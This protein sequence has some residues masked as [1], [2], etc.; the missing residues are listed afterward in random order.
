MRAS[1]GT[2]G[3]AALDQRNPR[4]TD[5]VAEQ[6]EATSATAE[7]AEEKETKARLVRA[8]LRGEVSR[9]GFLS[10]L[11]FAWALFTGATVGMLGAMGRFI[12]SSTWNCSTAC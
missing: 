9:R 4:T 3:R 7:E 12:K 10:T 11:G 5:P 8:P 6:K 1:M 2:R